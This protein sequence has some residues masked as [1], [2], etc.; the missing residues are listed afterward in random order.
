MAIAAITDR[1]STFR[2]YYLFG[3]AVAA[4]GCNGSYAMLTQKSQADQAVNHHVTVGLSFSIVH[5][6]EPRAEADPSGTPQSTCKQ[7]SLIHKPKYKCIPTNI[8]QSSSS[9]KKQRNNRCRGQVNLNFFPQFFF[10]FL[11]RRP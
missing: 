6:S 1:C 7:Y 10:F 5:Q 11:H 9:F 2:I 3:T 8:H 4:T